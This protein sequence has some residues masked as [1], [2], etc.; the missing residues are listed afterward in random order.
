MCPPPTT[1]KTFEE[2][3]NYIYEWDLISKFGEATLLEVRDLDE[4]AMPR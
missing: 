4:S 3:H 2:A 1:Q